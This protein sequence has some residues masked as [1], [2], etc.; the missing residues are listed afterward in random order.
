[1]LTLKSVATWCVLVGAVFLLGTRRV[2]AAEATGAAWFSLD[3]KSVAAGNVPD[4]QGLVRKF[5]SPVLGVTRTAR[6]DVQGT[7]LLLP[8]GG[9][10]ILDVNNEG[11]RTAEGLNG[12]GYDVAMLEYHVGAGAKSRDAAL[13]DVQ[14]AWKLLREKP[15]SLGVRGKRRVL[16]GY[17]A[18][19]HLAARFEQGLPPEQQPDDLML[20]Y[21]AYLEETA[22]GGSTPAVVPPAKIKSRL[23]VIQ[24]AD[25]RANWLAGSHAYVNAWQKA[26]GYGLM[27]QLKNGGHGFGMKPGL[28]GDAAEW[29]AMLNY[30]LE[31]GPKPGVGPFNT[32]LPWYLPN[33]KGRMATFEKDK[34]ADQGAV[35]FLG[36]SI[37]AKWNLAGVFGD[38]KVAN[39]GISGDTTRGMLCRLQD[40]VLDLHPKAIVYMGGINDFSQQPRGTAET[41]SENVQ[42]MLTQIQ[43]ADPKVPVLVCEILPAHFMPLETVRAANAAVDKVVAD[44]PNAHRV[45]TFAAF[46][47][48][49]GT[50]DASLFVDGTHPTAAGY[51]VWK[52]VL[53]PELAKYA[54]VP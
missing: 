3:G 24:A 9:Y 34:Q 14:A 22:P 26:G 5:E 13:A 48:A 18:G 39:R 21:P 1:M 8:G 44:F 4:D 43:A 38:L 52:R 29:P 31:N 42:L 54:R 19:G 37:T 7:V 51:E 11:A 32:V 45:K 23:V 6:A 28:T 27:Q 47:K 49:D 40:N 20:V 25:D 50:Q 53:E 10:S 46:L 17:S 12:F 2:W 41:I 16:M 35:V 30:F 15:E 36:D 33:V